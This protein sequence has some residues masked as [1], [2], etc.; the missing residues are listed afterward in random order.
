MS[1][2]P[3]WQT[4]ANKRERERHDE[5]LRVTAALERVS[6]SLSVFLG[7]ASAALDARARNEEAVIA[8]LVATFKTFS[9]LLLRELKNDL[10]TTK[11]KARRR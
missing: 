4:E 5:L 6:A 11:R 9:P 8:T 7:R 1:R 10:K 2:A 3:N